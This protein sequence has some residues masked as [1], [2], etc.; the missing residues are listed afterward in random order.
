MRNCDAN[1]ETQCTRSLL[2][3]SLGPRRQ[4]YVLSCLQRFLPN[5][6]KEICFIISFT[7]GIFDNFK[8][9]KLT[10]NL[11]GY[12]YEKLSG[13]KAKY[14]IGESVTIHEDFEIHLQ[15]RY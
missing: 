15:T 14:D 8:S 1:N 13:Q 5:P 6:L 12:Y 3:E 10:L 4:E 2:P 11:D 7:D 9:R